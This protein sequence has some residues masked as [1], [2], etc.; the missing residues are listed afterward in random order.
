MTRYGLRTPKTSTVAAPTVFMVYMAIPTL[1]ILG[2]VM[3]LVALCKCDFKEPFKAEIIRGVGTV[4]VPVGVIAG[5]VPIED[6]E[7]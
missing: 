2:W 7:E 5:Y 4:V 6:G 1:L 3:N